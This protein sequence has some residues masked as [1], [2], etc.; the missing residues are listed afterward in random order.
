MLGGGFQELFAVSLPF[1]SGIVAVG[2]FKFQ[3]FPPVMVI[4]L[5][6]STHRTAAQGLKCWCVQFC[7]ISYQVILG[8]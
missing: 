3:F 6:S 4:V 1:I 5:I 2:I 8:A 7:G